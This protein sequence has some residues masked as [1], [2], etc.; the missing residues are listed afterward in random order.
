MA[1]STGEAHISVGKVFDPF[2]DENSKVQ[3]ARALGLEKLEDVK[4]YQHQIERLTEWGKA[5]GAKD[6]EDLIWQ[7]KQLA[8]RIGGPRFGELNVRNL[9][10]YAYLE[11]ERMK[12]D[13]Q[14]KEME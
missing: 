14:L 2:V 8:N 6:M 10:T 4:K 5:K 12:I 7:V 13:Q 11:L 3:I 9:A 1:D